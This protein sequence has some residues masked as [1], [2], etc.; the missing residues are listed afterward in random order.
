M[1]QLVVHVLE[2]GR[3]YVHKADHRD[4]TA[5]KSQW[6]IDEADERG[7]LSK[8]VASSWC[9]TEHAWGVHRVS[10]QVRHLGIAQNRVTQL[11]VAKYVNGQNNLWHGYPADPQ[12]HSQD[13]PPQYVLN[14]WLSLDILPAA[15]IR[16][17]Q[18][19]QRC[20]L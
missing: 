3:S 5:A 20:Q 19:G 16:K 18:R 12:R 17:I 11:F 8:S 10:G 2:C 1:S 13:I 14:S 9:D 4:G 6:S 15:K 7:C